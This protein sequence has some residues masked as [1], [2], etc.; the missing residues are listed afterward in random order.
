MIEEDGIQ[1]SWRRHSRRRLGDAVEKMLEP[2]VE[3]IDNKLGTNIKGCAGCQK[4][5]EILNQLDEKISNTFDN[6]E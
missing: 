4:R 1:R 6:N 2:V 3:V 5:K